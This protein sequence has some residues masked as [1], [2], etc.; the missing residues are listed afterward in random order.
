M[1][2]LYSLG[3]QGNISS[4]TF[5]YEVLQQLE[6]DE[7]VRKAAPG[8]GLQVTTDELTET[9]NGYLTSAA[10]GGGNTTGNVTG[11]ITLSQTDLDKIYQQWLKQVRL[12]NSEYRQVIEATLLT[13]KLKEQLRQN[14]PTAAKHVHVYAIKVDNEGNATEIE[15]RLQNGEDFATLAA[16]FSTDEATNQYGGEIG[17]V[18]Q[19]I[20]IPELDQAAFSLAA[21]NISEPILASNGYYYIVKAAEIEDNR[22]IDDQSREMLATTAFNNWFKEQKNIV[23]IREYLDETKITW[24]LNHIT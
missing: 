13:Q 5:P 9:I 11:N 19:G 2:R 4:T 21:G 24:A 18:S 6:N 17:W 15:N 8:L 23:E 20:L 16:E 1:L 22:P 10:G 14:V 3:S 12:S 7:L